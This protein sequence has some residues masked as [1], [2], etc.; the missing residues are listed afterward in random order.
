[1]CSSELQALTSNSHRQVGREASGMMQNQK[2]RAVW[3][4]GPLL[5]PKTQVP[6][7]QPP[8]KL[9][10]SRKKYL[11][12]LKLVSEQGAWRCMAHGADLKRGNK[13][14]AFRPSPASPAPSQSLLGTS[15]R[16]SP[17]RARACPPAFWQEG[18]G[19]AQLLPHH[20]P[21][22]LPRSPPQKH[23]CSS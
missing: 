15:P 14:S 19:T 22:P 3:S 1:M 18:W 7:T 9:S 16:N 6:P 12:L 2:T 4:T 17:R 5:A 13:E 8:P 21:L 11:Q 20:C 10:S 23:H